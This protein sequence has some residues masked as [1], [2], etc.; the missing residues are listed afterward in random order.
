MSG[1]GGRPEPVPGE[2]REALTAL[3]RRLEEARAVVLTTHVNADGDGAG[4]EAAVA[5]WLEQRGTTVHIVNPTPF[6]EEF[7]FVLP[8]D[9]VVAP[10]GAAAT[11]EILA[12]ADLIFVLDTAEPKRV[13][14]LDRWLGRGDV[15]VLDHHPTAEG[16]IQGVG[17]ADPTAAA[18][19]ELVYDLL[20]IAEE[21][22]QR[23]GGAARPWPPSLVEALYTAIV[24]DTGSFRFAN[25]TPRVHRIVADLLHRGVD[26]E[27]LYRRIYGT[28]PL[29]QVRLLRSALEGLDA[30]PELPLTWISVPWSVARASGATSRDF[31]GLVEHARSVEGTEIAILFREVADGSTKVSLRSNGAADVNA[32]ARAFGG[33]GHVKAAGTVIGAPLTEA[34]RQVLGAARAA[35][36]TMGARRPRP[37]VLDSPGGDTA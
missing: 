30:D 23:K 4:S 20:R 8:G 3:L 25:T 33:G 21:E 6:P 34:R 26:P 31:D 22:E 14:K 1:E 15:A 36:E 27:K 9:A 32:I 17:L 16:A 12:A 24:T 5:A 18:T 10:L 37:L 19:G 28:V 7:R 13:G 2:R 35:L 29:S 11:R